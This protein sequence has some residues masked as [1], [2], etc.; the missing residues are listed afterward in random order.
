[1]LLTNLQIGRLCKAFAN[2][3]SANVKLSKL[4]WHKIEQWGWFLDRLVEP[5]LKTRLPLIK[6]VIKH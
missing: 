5:L 1:M 2:N 4:N 6:Y 3:S